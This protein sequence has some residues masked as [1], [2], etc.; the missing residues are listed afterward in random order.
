MG[1]FLGHRTALIYCHNWLGG[2][3]KSSP[4]V[5]NTLHTINIDNPEKSL[6]FRNCTNLDRKLDTLYKKNKI[7]LNAL[8]EKIIYNKIIT[9]EYGSYHQEIWNSFI[10]TK[11][12]K[13]LCQ[14]VEYS[15]YFPDA[16]L[17]IFN[18][19]FTGKK[20]H[21]SNPYDYIY[22][23]SF[24]LPVDFYAL[25]DLPTAMMQLLTAH[26]QKKYKEFRENCFKPY[27][28]EIRDDSNVYRLDVPDHNTMRRMAINEKEIPEKISVIN[29][30][31][32]FLEQCLLVRDTRNCLADDVKNI[33]IAVAIISKFNCSVPSTLALNWSTS[34][35]Q[36]TQNEHSE[37]LFKNLFEKLK[38]RIKEQMIL[39]ATLVPG[40]PFT[41]T[42]KNKLKEIIS[43]KAVFP[44]YTCL[45][46]DQKEC[47]A[48][49][50]KLLKNSAII[51]E[52]V[53]Q[54]SES[55]EQVLADWIEKQHENS[56]PVPTHIYLIVTNG[57]GRVTEQIFRILRPNVAF[58]RKIRAQLDAL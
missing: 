7:E 25:Y 22:K 47:V 55:Y 19:V 20:F 58:V 44:Q 4:H 48:V 38:D 51:I 29:I 5:R 53:I 43:N 36:P 57:E 39:L 23:T 27:F 6:Q 49:G 2:N 3:E 37:Y 54:N 18:I 41:I 26:N 52:T 14:R 24:H 1:W 50:E 11:D 16:V 15:S 8:V 13:P 34:I 45:A 32:N 42:L 35:E 46:R 40:V 21:G 56:Q 9:G 33:D 31:D 12:S 17:I 28:Y 10:Q 30:Y